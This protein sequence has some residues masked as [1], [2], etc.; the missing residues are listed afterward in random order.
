MILTFVSDGEDIQI[1]STHVTGLRRGSD[2][3]TTLMMDDDTLI[4]VTEPFDSVH[5][6]LI[7]ADEGYW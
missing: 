6:K 4:H 5:D 3:S 1:E 7:V 2:S